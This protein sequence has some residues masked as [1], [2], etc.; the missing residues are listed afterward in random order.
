MTQSTLDFSILW[1]SELFQP[2]PALDSEMLNHWG[3]IPGLKDLLMLRQVHALEHATVW[4]LSE[5]GQPT[6]GN[7]QN[8]AAYQPDSQP[9]N[10]TLGGLSTE[11]GFYLYGDVNRLDIQRAVHQALRRCQQGEW[12]L[13]VHPRCGTN[14][15]VNLFLTAALALGVHLI[16]PRSPVEQLIGIGLAATAA[17]QISPDMGLSVQK[18]M[19][20]AIPFNLELVDIKPSQDFWQ[21]SGHFVEVRWQDL[22]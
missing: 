16:L 15:S 20:T 12:Q 17:A 13:A 3:F 6:I 10:E 8:I 1:D 19:T 14:V 18:Y 22:Q 7:S 2:Q 21:R 11:K 5:K 4:V 9:D